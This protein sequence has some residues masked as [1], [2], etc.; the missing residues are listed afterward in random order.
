MPKQANT[1][2]VNV[3]KTVTV[4]NKVHP[5]GLKTNVT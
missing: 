1:T 2:S 3:T 4:E 5:V